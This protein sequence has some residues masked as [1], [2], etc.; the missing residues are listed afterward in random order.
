MIL[1]F[2]LV[3]NSMRF[4]EHIFET[5]KQSL[6]NTFYRFKNNILCNIENFDAVE[7]NYN[8]SYKGQN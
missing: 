5:L 7:I 3:H 4:F 2:V 1:W 6:K 8:F